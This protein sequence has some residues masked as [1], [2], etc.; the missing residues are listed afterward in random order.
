MALHGMTRFPSSIKIDKFT[1]NKMAKLSI[2]PF[3]LYCTVNVTYLGKDV[4]SCRHAILLSVHP[5]IIYLYRFIF[6]D[7]IF[8]HLFLTPIPLYLQIK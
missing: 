6:N 2:H 8:L 3:N 4:G 1:R 5:T 7:S